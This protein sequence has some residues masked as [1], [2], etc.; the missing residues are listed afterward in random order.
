[1][2]R[3]IEGREFR[4][5]HDRNSG[6][7]FANLEFRYCRFINSWLSTTN[8]PKRRSTVREVKLTGCE[9]I[10]CVVDTAI[11]ED[12]IVDGLK[13]HGLLQTWG[14]VFKHV[15]LKG[16]IGRIMIS[17]SVAT[18]TAKPKVQQAF[19]EANATYYATVDWALDI[20]EARFLECDIRSVPA[21][22]IIR[23]P[24]TQVV[25][26][27]E[28]A[29]EGKW[30]KLDLSRTYWTTAI[31]YL[32]DFGLTDLVLIAPKRGSKYRELLD[33]LKMLRDVGVAEPD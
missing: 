25:V 13:T 9:E 29:L 12:V 18:G 20:S 3:I 16:Y 6:R 7:T 19:D 24:E 14:A 10:G 5:L 28:K 27:R 4:S 2:N 26:T 32:L 22:L 21:K 11:I 1:M 17:P 33:G 31:E 15:T 8:N 23:D 30:R